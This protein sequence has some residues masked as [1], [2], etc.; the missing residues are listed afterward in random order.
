MGLFVGRVYLVCLSG[1][2][3]SSIEIPG[4]STNFLVLFSFAF[5]IVRSNFC[6]FV[7][8]LL[9]V[10]MKINTNNIRENFMV[11]FGRRSTPRKV[12]KTCS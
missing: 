2:N 1:P 9:M 10:Y 3:T 5:H 8:I 4:P 6:L 12:F 7:G 11:L